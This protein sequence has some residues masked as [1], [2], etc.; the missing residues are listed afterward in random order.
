MA[1]T[2][3]Y[4]SLKANGTSFY[5]F[6]GAQEDISAAYQNSNYKM[7]FSKYVLLNLPKQNPIPGLQNKPVYFDFENSFERSSIATPATSFKDSIIESL[8]NYVSNHEVVM[9][10]SRMNNTKY[11]YDTNALETAT[12]KI[13]WKWCKKLKLIDFEPANQ[14][15]E[16]FNQLTEFASNDV[17]SEDYHPEILW[18]EREVTTFDA[19][20]FYET[21]NVLHPQKLEI[22]FLGVTNFRVG[23]L[24][25][26]YNVI[27]TDI[28]DGINAYAPPPYGPLPGPNGDNAGYDLQLGVNTT[29]LSITPAGAT[30][31]QLIVFDLK[32]TSNVPAGGNPGQEP[33]GKVELVYNRLVQYI[34]EVTGV[35]NVQEANRSYTEVYAHIPDHTGR[36]PD[37]LFRTDVDTNYKPNMTFPILPSQYQPEILG[38]ELFNSPIVSTPQNYPGSY[39]GQ[40]D[41]ADYTY[42]TASGDELRRT[43]PYFGVSGLVSAPV[44]DGSSID[45]INIDFDKGHYTKMNLP[46]SPIT[47]FDQFNAQST[48]N[49]PP[50]SF[51]Y[52]AV[53]WYY[54]VEDANGVIRTNLYGISFLDNPDNNPLDEEVGLRFPVYKKLVSDG[55][56]DGTSYSFGLNLNFNIIN[57]NANLAYNPEAIN[58]LFSMNLFNSAMSR[59]GSVN[60]SFQNIISEQQFI[61]QQIMDMKSMLYT[62]TD[63]NVLNTKIANLD[64]LLRLYSTL[65]IRSSES[66]N[67][68]SLPGN[69]P[70][71]ALFNIDPYYNTVATI[72]TTSMYSEQGAIPYIVNVP[73]NKSFLVNVV[74]ND[75]VELD[76]PSDAKLVLNIDSDL[77]LRQVLDINIYPSEF[78]SQNKK[79]DIYMRSD[80]TGSISEVLLLGEIDLPVSYNPGLQL[81][82]SSYLWN[83]FSFEIDFNQKINYID[84]DLLEIPFKENTEIIYNSIKPGDTLVL[85]DFF[86]KDPSGGSIYDF[87]SQYVVDSVVSSTSSYIKLDISNNKNLVAFG[88]S[89]S[90]PFTMHGSTSS[91]SLLANKP[92]FSL[93]KGK[94]VRITKISNSSILAE[95]Y[96]IEVNDI[97]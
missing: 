92:Y 43:G 46:R 34:G 14:Q 64:T 21:A 45:G 70:S 25:N 50:K 48:N 88:A 66:I 2:P 12:E 55:T 80:Y 74:N 75:E 62:Q 84:G 86:V 52:N 85:N 29:V 30:Q 24:V 7:Y 23:D 94:K 35:S 6:P 65:Q 10:E 19:I 15:D 32:F 41:T 76:L 96:Y 31:G 8:R 69:P 38:A 58:S 60:D 87:S 95:R 59:L 26:I 40:F 44:I 1:S 20:R 13:F 16:Y 79:L 61:N 28:I 77:A 51:E 67:V 91:T 22:E 72:E 90:L 49:Q 53:L 37:I 39:Y 18:K 54:T 68:E 33:Y 63:I 93:N 78:S 57:E 4:K 5:A 71:I 11:Y 42:E 73:V 97:M 3:L 83:N 27:D 56:Q 82:N 36:T 17:N 81:P 89:Q 47:N 9:R